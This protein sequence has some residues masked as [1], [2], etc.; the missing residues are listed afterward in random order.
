MNRTFSPGIA[1][2]HYP[3]PTTDAKTLYS[4]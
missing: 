1:C 2:Y 4:I 3:Y